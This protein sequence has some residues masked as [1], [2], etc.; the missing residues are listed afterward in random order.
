MKLARRTFFLVGMTLLCAFSYLQG[1]DEGVKVRFINRFN[2][3]VAGQDTTFQVYI[4]NPSPQAKVLVGHLDIPPSWQAVP[5]NDI[6]FHLM[7]NQNVVQTLVVRIPDYQ[8]AGEFPISYEI[9]GREDPNVYNKDTMIL[10]LQDPADSTCGQD[11]IYSEAPETEPVG[12]SCERTLEDEEICLKLTSASEVLVDMNGFFYVSCLIKNKSPEPYKDT[13]TLTVPEDWQ[14]VPAQAIEVE[15]PPLESHLQIFAV[16]TPPH[17]LAERYPLSL[18]LRKKPDYPCRLGAKIQK[19]GG[20][21]VEWVEPLSYYPANE[22]IDLTLD[23]LNLGNS[24]LKVIFE[25]Q[26]DPLCQLFYRE[27]PIEIPPHDRYRGT[28]RVVPNLTLDDPKQFIRYKVID[29]ATGEILYQDTLTLLFNSSFDE[30][31]D[32]LLRISS[33]VSMMAL[34]DNGREV[35]AVEW[36]GFGLIDPERERYL[37]F[38]FRIPTTTKNVIYGVDQRLY[39]SIRQPLWEINL[40]DT[41]Y[42][43]SPLTQEYRYGRGAGFDVD[44]GTYTLG[45]H[46]TQNTYNNDYNPKEA[47]AYLGCYPNEKL[48]IWGNYLH[49]DCREEPTSNIVSLAAE[50]DWTQNIHT[51]IEAGKDLVEHVGKADKQAFRF[52]T[53]GQLGEETWFD[54][55]KI[56]AGRAFFGYYNHID[57]YSG[58]LDF[59]LTYPMRANVGMTRLIQNFEDDDHDADDFFATKPRQRQYSAN[60]SYNFSNG[61]SLTWNGLLLRARDAG[62][63]K[64]YDFYQ[65]WA[66]FTTSFTAQGWNVVAIAAWGRQHNYLKHITNEFLQRYY[67]FLSKQ[68]GENLFSTLFYEGGNTNYYDAEPWRTSYGGSLAYRYQSNSFIELYLQRVNNSCDEYELNQAS[69]RLLHTFR[70]RHTLQVSTQY[71][72]YQTHY[73]NDFLFLVSYSIPFGLPV[74]VRNDIGHVSGSVFNPCDHSF[75]SDAL[76]SLGG[77]QCYTDQNGRFDFKNLKCGTYDLKTEILP[78]QVIAQDPRPKR[79]D[80]VG[81]TTT[82]VTLPVAHSGLI[83]GEVVRYSLPGPTALTLTN[84]EKRWRI[85][86]K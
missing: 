28:L 29:C 52:N 4:V 1:A 25:A 21:K 24:P 84:P 77:K 67:C 16:K 43:L 68:I 60:V 15:I 71:F 62:Q 74:G 51:E 26:A 54:F 45:S 32:P 44:T 61:A 37:D 57:M 55:E 36:A 5:A 42:R 23:Y 7:P 50:Y 41:V 53:Y 22:P 63:T 70:N 38:V 49:R 76:I 14:A 65:K 6:L 13:L 11:F 80:V 82:E 75:V 31:G 9:W 64:Q 19:S 85:A 48:Y 2:N 78:R 58:I 79:V 18:T 83:Y 66:G 46:Y 17:C 81:G 72:H 35:L 34:G 40:G 56:Y 20:F 30:D 73:P 69:L 33:H 8:T 39:A 3:A 27:T 10:L 86:R 47:A 12:L 59:P